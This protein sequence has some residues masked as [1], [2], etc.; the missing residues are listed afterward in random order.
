[1]E[2]VE[3][4]AAAGLDVDTPEALKAAGGELDEPA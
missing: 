2:R 3:I 1:M 4:G